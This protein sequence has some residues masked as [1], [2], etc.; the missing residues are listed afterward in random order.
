M[1]A[2]QTAVTRAWRVSIDDRAERGGL[3]HIIRANDRAAALEQARDWL[4]LVYPEAGPTD[5]KLTRIK[6]GR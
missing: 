3:D 4:R 6:A 2:S 5:F 1:S